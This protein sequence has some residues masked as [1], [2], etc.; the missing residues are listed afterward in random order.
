MAELFLSNGMKV[1]LKHR[2]EEYLV[3]VVE[4]IR[5]IIRKYLD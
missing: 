2:L 1:R 4:K 3:N 5:E